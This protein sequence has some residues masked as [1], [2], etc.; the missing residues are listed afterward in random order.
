MYFCLREAKASSQE[1]CVFR[2]SLFSSALWDGSIDGVSRLSEAQSISGLSIEPIV[3]SFLP[4]HKPSFSEQK[5]LSLCS[6]QLKIKIQQ[7]KQETFSYNISC[8]A[9]LQGQYWV[10]FYCVCGSCHF[11]FKETCIHSVHTH[12]ENLSFVLK[13]GRFMFGGF[14]GRTIIQMWSYTQGSFLRSA[15]AEGPPRVDWHGGRK[16]EKAFWLTGCYSHLIPPFSTWERQ[17]GRVR[18]SCGFGFRG[19]RFKTKLQFRVPDNLWLVLCHPASCL[20]C[21]SIYACTGTMHVFASTHLVIW[22]VR[23]HMVEYL[24]KHRL[25]SLPL[26]QSRLNMT[27]KG[28][29]GWHKN[30]IEM[31]VCREK[32]PDVEW[33]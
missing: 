20:T 16:C 29:K 3:L 15:I 11:F 25:F 2:L 22:G 23:G 19:P 31:Y 27:S 14:L 12:W 21:D 13:P 4:H 9:F 30:K 28:N 26:S 18:P 33:Y 5:E 6:D 8:M 32:R 24:C 7:Y 17:W 10:Q 1:S